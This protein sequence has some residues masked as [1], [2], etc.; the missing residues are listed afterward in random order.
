MTCLLRVLVLDDIR[1]CVR[2]LDKC[3]AA[4]EGLSE[5]Y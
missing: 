1:N 4:L 3:M 2:A 5:M